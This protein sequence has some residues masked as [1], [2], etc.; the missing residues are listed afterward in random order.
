[1]LNGGV[2][3][4]ADV[5]RE[6]AWAD[7]VMLG[8][9]VVQ[10]PYLLAKLGEE[11]FGRQAP[12]RRAALT[13]MLEAAK[14]ESPHEWRRIAQSLSGLLHGCKNSRHYR[15]SLNLP[16]PSALIQLAGLGFC[17]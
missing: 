14:N 8:R 12:T 13:H 17:Q 7:G 3:S 6:T 2:Q 11:F 16:M 15:R 9:T 10:E 5:R 1:M 4:I